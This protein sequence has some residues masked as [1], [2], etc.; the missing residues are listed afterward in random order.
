M[1]AYKHCYTDLLSR[2]T[3]IATLGVYDFMIFTNEVIHNLNQI[4][5]ASDLTL[6]TYVTYVGKTSIE[7]NND[8]Y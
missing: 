4:D 5:Y 7:I 2:K 1:V 8:I 3:T 6:N